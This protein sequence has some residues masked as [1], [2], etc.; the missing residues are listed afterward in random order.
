MKK[1]LLV[2]HYSGAP[3][4]PIDKLYAYLK[5]EN[6][7]F[8]IKHPLFP[9]NKHKSI[10][11]FEK[12]DLQFKIPSIIQYPI[13]G[14]LASFFL[15]LK[16]K[17]RP[18]VD[19][20]ISFDPL[21]FL[22]SYLF[23]WIIRS[24]KIIYLNLDYSKKRFSN[25][26]INFIYNRINVFAYVKSDYFFSLSTAIVNDMDPKGI[27]EYKNILMKHTVSIINNKTKKKKNSLIY[28]GSITTGM[29]FE[30]LLLGIKKY[31]NENGKCT[32][33]IYGEENDQGKLQQMII[34]YGLTENV[35]LKGPVDMSILITEIIPRYQIGVAVYKT[36]QDKS[37]PDYLFTGIDLTAK[38]VDYISAGLPV[39]TPRLNSGFDCIESKKF[40]F[41]VRN[42]SDWLSTIKSLLVNR[43]LYLQ[44]SSNATHY[45]H[46]YDE[47]KVFKP[48]FKKV[49][50]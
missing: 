47:E 25:R 1:I 46:N 32:L 24:K 10:I 8:I 22:N 7:V 13:E 23:R 15:L 12:I 14:L 6:R 41:L 35:I 45:A 49:F 34:S 48:I 18:S 16:F 5:K 11:K 50:C 3:G 38:I 19:L 36:T 44:Y 9:K 42:D 28:A 4:G 33:D 31:K 20:I 37:A 30:P 2:S 21:S 17:K 29:S 39:I 26:I 43:K 27:Y 40:G